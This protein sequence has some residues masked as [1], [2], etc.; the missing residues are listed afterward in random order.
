[1]KTVLPKTG[2]EIIVKVNECPVLHLRE[3]FR[4]SVIK[5]KLNETQDGHFIQEET[6]V[7][8]WRC[9]GLL[10]KALKKDLSTVTL[11]AHFCPSAHLCILSAI[12]GLDRR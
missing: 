4:Q 1:M 7:Y 11:G 12:Y 5:K 10:A 2:N 3:S 9:L 6:L 8:S